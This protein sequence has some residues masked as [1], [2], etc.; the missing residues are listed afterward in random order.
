MQPDAPEPRDTDSGAD[1]PARGRP[2]RWLIEI[3]QTL[4][5][6]VV[7]LFVIQAFVAQAYQVQ[8]PS[9]RTTLEEGQHVLVD[10]LTPRL[11]GYSRGDI[12]VFHPVR[13]EG[14]CSDTAE[15]R[16]GTAFIKRVIGL[17][18]DRIE[19]RDGAVHINGALLDEPY[20]QGLPT[21]PLGATWVVPEDRL[22]LMGDNR[23]DSIDS[24]TDDIGPICVSDVVG[25]AFLRFAPLDA[26]GILA[27]PSYAEVQPSP[28][29]SVDPSATR[30]SPASP[31][32]SSVTSAGAPA[33]VER[34]RVEVI[35]RR[36]HDRTSYTQGLVM[37]GG[38]LYE[39]SGHGPVRLR[40]VEPRTGAVLRSVSVAD[41]YF[42]EGIA[43]VDDRLI[44]LTWQEHT[45]LVYSLA[46]LREVA[47]FTY[48]TEGWGLCDDGKRLVMSDGT[49]RLYFRDRTTF[50]LL[51]SVSVTREGAPFAGLNELECVGGDVY[52][53]V[54]PT[55][56]IV[57]VDAS[58][59]NVTA[60]IDAAGLLAP[61]EAPGDEGAVLNGIAY[62]ASSATFLLTGKLWPTMFEVRFVPG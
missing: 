21:G 25:R 38:R 41:R 33:A 37:A 40:E 3:A 7:V 24:R 16:G 45:A 15:L 2:F 52:A 4:L 6:A 44:Q 62:D 27:T 23:P 57:R 32:A 39:S 9:M 12:V 49:S 47:T 10:K 43:V 46:D 48:D 61:G 30:S 56:T 1:R 51:G 29:A 11:G 31:T 20:V 17:P 42:T 54:W 53:N 35:A 55:D 14:S 28:G 58:T 5:L 60:V 36:P 13:R 26:F 59:G 18:G 19:L 34:L 50:E 22:F 8:Q